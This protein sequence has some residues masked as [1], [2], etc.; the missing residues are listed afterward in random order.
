MESSADALR[1]CSRD[2]SKESIARRSVEIE[3]RIEKLK[4][5]FSAACAGQDE[6][7][8]HFNNFL[9][10]KSGQSPGFLDKLLTWFPEDACRWSTADPGRYRLSA[11]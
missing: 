4:R 6:F 7:G 2:L 10:R 9:A 5:R 1:I 11:H 8:G 3:N